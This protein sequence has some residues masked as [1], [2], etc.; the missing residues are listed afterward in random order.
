M[1][2]FLGLACKGVDCCFLVLH[3]RK[4]ARVLCKAYMGVALDCDCEM[5]HWRRNGS[6]TM[7][8]IEDRMH[9]LTE[10][11]Q[12]LHLRTKLGP[13]DSYRKWYL[14]CTKLRLQF[15]TKDHYIIWT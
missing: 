13:F 2:G 8:S 10:Q 4:G 12:L 11:R 3:E 15:Q 7:E 5:V 1:G 14:M 9:S 6:L